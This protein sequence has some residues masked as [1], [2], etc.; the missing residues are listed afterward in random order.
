MWVP[1][2]PRVC[3]LPKWDILC[4][5]PCDWK[6]KKIVCKKVNFLLYKT[7]RTIVIIR[8]PFQTQIISIYLFTERYKAV[9]LYKQKLHT[10]R[11]LS[12]FENGCDISH[13]FPKN[14]SILTGFLKIVFVSFSHKTDSTCE[15]QLLVPSI[16]EEGQNSRGAVLNPILVTFYKHL[17]ESKCHFIFIFASIFLRSWKCISQGILQGMNLFIIFFHILVIARK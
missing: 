14:C 6:C 12:Q 8:V 15:I 7:T 16:L 10:L 1:P 2:P 9:K 4:L 13:H 5:F 3:H 17:S 11:Y